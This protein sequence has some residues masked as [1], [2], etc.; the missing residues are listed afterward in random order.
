MSWNDVCFMCKNDPTL[1]NK[2]RPKKSLIETKVFCNK[3]SVGGKEFYQ[4]SQQGFKPEIVIEVYLFEYQ[5][6]SHVK[7]RNKLYR[8]IRHYEKN[9]ETIELVCE[10]LVNEQ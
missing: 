9:S 1:D 5:D 8:I 4:A 2:N 10:A 3:K 6:H 7:Y